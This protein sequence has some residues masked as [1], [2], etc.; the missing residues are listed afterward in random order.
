MR[1]RTERGSSLVLVLV[2]ILFLAA[3]LPAILGLVFTGS[4][5]T[6][7]EIRD[8]R[9]V[10]AAMSALDAAVQLGRSEPDIGVPGGAC[11]EQRLSIDGFEAVV[12]PTCPPITAA[13]EW[14]YADRFA[15]YTIE[16]RSP[17]GEVVATTT[18]EV[19]YRFD[20]DVPWT[21]EV[22]QVD[23]SASGPA[24]TTTL[25]ACPGGASAPPTT[26]TS[27]TVPQAGSYARWETSPLTAVPLPGNKW[28]AE[29]TLGVSDQAGRPLAGVDVTIRVETR[30][31]AGDWEGPE[32]LT[33]PTNQ[34]GSVTF[35]SAA[36]NNPVKGIRF[37]V[38]AVAAP[39]LT[40]NSAAHSTAESVTR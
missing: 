16:V 22:R 1:V 30:A 2:V 38:T 36:F 25:P 21:A 13:A 8:R 6:Q 35:H 14:C 19:V 10:Y 24:T 15:S 39:G 20:P 29:G 9:E 3:M 17:E 27:T 26:S 11:P 31:D 28:R 40:W 34:T 23:P 32:L 5:V 12:T 18:S 7:V 33:F 4:R 37:T